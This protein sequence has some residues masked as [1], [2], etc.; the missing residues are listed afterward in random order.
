VLAS[1]LPSGLKVKS[2]MRLSVL[3]DLTEPGH[4]VR[5]RNDSSWK[6]IRLAVGSS[7]LLGGDDEFRGV[8]L[9]RAPSS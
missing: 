2:L 3:V 5:H 8:W 4:Y 6:L 9:S 7:M 1:R